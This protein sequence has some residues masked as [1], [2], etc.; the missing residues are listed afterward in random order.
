[1]KAE[2]KF[3]MDCPTHGTIEYPT[4]GNFTGKS[5]YCFDCKDF[6]GT[7]R[8]ITLTVGKSAG[9]EECDNRCLQ[10]KRSCGCKCKGACHGQ[11]TCNPD[12]HPKAG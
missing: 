10:G 11:Q 6:T 5:A 1:M 7:A 2:Q 4:A 3:W 12:F 8:I 9:K